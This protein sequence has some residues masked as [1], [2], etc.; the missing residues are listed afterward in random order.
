MPQVCKE[1]YWRGR[2]NTGFRLVCPISWLDNIAAKLVAQRGETRQQV[3]YLG[4]EGCIARTLQS[5][6]RIAFVSI[7]LTQAL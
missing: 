2:R 4:Y 7:A 5:K 3:R 6:G 1:R